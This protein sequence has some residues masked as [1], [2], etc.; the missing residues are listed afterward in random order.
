MT[1]GSTASLLDPSQLRNTLALI[2]QRGKT[3]IIWDIAFN[4]G[5]MLSCAAS[6]GDCD[7]VCML[8]V[9]MVAV[10]DTEM[11]GQLVRARKAFFASVKCA[12]EWLFAS[13]CANV[14]GLEES[15]F[16]RDNGD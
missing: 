16:L 13:M 4:L 11:P 7:I 14:T 1:V 3:G 2:V 15:K 10:V 5:L 9:G 12:L 8:G 6:A